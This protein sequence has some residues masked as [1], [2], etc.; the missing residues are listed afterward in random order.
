MNRMNLFRFPLK[1][2]RG[3]SLIFS[4]AFVVVKMVSA[5]VPSLYHCGQGI[6]YRGVKYR[7]VI[8]K[9]CLLYQ[10]IEVSECLGAL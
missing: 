8:S 2:V 3:F 7:S 6:V 1:G 10:G 4:E 9:Y 5:I